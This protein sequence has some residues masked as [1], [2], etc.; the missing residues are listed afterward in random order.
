MPNPLNPK[1]V[2]AFNQGYST[3]HTSMFFTTHDCPYSTPEYA[4]AWCFGLQAGY[5]S[6]M[7]TQQRLASIV[8]SGGLEELFNNIAVMC[9]QHSKSARMFLTIQRQMMLMPGVGA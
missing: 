9:S 4:I 3:S 5:E 7:P 6:Q 2:F 8:A 1:I